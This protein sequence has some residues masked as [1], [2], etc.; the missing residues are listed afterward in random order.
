L[1]RITTH[2]NARLVL[3]CMSKVSLLSVICLSIS[4][5][6]ISLLIVSV[7]SSHNMRC[8]WRPLSLLLSS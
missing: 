4:T 6:M 8:L 7:G 3:V 5:L 2:S 1:N